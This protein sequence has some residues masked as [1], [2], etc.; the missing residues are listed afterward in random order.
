MRTA[1]NP[2][3]IKIGDMVYLVCKDESVSQFVKFEVMH[4]MIPCEGD[5]YFK[6]SGVETR[7]GKKITAS[8]RTT[9]NLPTDAY[10]STTVF[11]REVD[12][13]NRLFVFQE[14][15]PF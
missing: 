7:E 1:L 11:F 14:C 6:V 5:I 15:T 10:K 13:C 12:F 2:S 3:L 9:L 8:L 4:V